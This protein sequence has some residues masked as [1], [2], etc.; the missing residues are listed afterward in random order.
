MK[1]AIA[2]AIAAFCCITANAQEI[3]AVVTRPSDGD[4]NYYQITSNP[5]VVLGNDNTI[6]FKL[7]DTQQGQ[8]YTLTGSN[9]Y[10]VLF[11]SVISSEVNENN[12]T[13]SH[14]IIITDGG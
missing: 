3:N 10:T 8:P 11:S 9:T 2:I 6:T 5:N 7:G 12:L 14:P 4:Q 1:K 13:V